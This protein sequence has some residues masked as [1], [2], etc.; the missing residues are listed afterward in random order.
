MLLLWLHRHRT[1][2]TILPLVAL[3]ITG[4]F[5]G[6]G[7]HHTSLLWA[8]LIAALW[9]TWDTIDPRMGKSWLDRTFAVLLVLVLAE[10]ICW[11]AAATRFDIRERFDGSFD[12]A[13]FLASEVK[14]QPIAGFNYHSVAVEPYFDR[15]LFF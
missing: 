8:S 10:Q 5:L 12:A 14:F 1:L 7:A 2:P 13:R 6:F 9:I 3:A 4:F 11:T 15:K